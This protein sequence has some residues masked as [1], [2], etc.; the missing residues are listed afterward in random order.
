MKKNNNKQ[1]VKKNL[2]RVERKYGK[3]KIKRVKIRFGRIMLLFLILFFIFYIMSF[4][5]SF[6]I[7]NIYVS[8]N[9]ILSD[10]EIIELAELELYP[11]YFS[12][13]E[14]KL[15]KKIEKN[16]YVKSV[17]VNKKR[18]KEIYIE[19]EENTPLF[20]DESK[21]K[22][23]LKDKT[24]VEAKFNTPI[25]LNYIPDTLYEEF[26]TNMINIDINIKG[27]IS[28]IKYVPNDVD[29]ERFLLTMVDGNYVYTT[30][31]KMN[32]INH[33]I[34]IMKEV[35]KTYETDKGILY[36]DEGEYFE[37]FK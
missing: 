13:T 33:Y 20:Y 23:V 18:L 36:L 10:Q 9:S 15:E 32:K 17:S 37:V 27:R 35:L 26:I 22:T 30:L 2:S 8:G 34:E 29:E 5:I 21:E 16:T 7:K 24:V 12:C 4:I 6:P 11:S 28:E 14:S 3:K 25:L 19:I 31:S 1:P